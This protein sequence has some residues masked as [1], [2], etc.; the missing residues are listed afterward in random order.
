M[1]HKYQQMCI[2]NI[3]ALRG[4][5]HLNSYPSQFTDALSQKYSSLL[6]H[7]IKESRTW[8]GKVFSVLWH[9]TLKVHPKCPSAYL[10][11]VA[12]TQNSCQLSVENLIKVLMAKVKP[13]KIW[14]C[15]FLVRCFFIPQTYL[16]IRMTATSLAAE[17]IGLLLRSKFLSYSSSRHYLLCLLV[18]VF[19]PEPSVQTSHFSRGSWCLSSLPKQFLLHFTFIFSAISSCFC[20]K[21]YLIYF[22][23][24]LDHSQF[25]SI[26]LP[27]TFLGLLSV[28]LIAGSLLSYVHFCE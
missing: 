10:S 4:D 1:L 8:F 9:F 26:I 25:C 28:H 12:H 21:A 17:E 5:W 11:S 2:W 24:C 23:L 14:L 15:C 22:S 13:A 16:T 19:C 20:G 18:C 27:L 3:Q 6:E 7:S